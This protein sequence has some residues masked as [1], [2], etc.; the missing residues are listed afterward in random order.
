MQAQLRSQTNA[1]H[2]LGVAR[3]GVQSVE[4]WVSLDEDDGAGALLAGFLEAREHL[5][6]LSQA[7]INQKSTRLNSSHVSISYA[8]FC[9]KKK[10]K[11]KKKKKTINHNYNLVYNINTR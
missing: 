7:C 3:V 10:I 8:V 2:R 6:P 1:T 11:N 9:L 5:V 4:R